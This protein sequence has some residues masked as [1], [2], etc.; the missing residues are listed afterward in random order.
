MLVKE[1][2]VI[3]GVVIR[4]V[5]TVGNWVYALVVVLEG[6]VGSVITDGIVIVGEKVVVETVVEGVVKIN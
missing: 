4:R 5:L 2:I 3:V 1:D 6:E